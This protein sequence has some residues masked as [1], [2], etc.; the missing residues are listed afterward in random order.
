[1]ISC[2]SFRFFVRE[3]SSEIVLPSRVDG[4]RLLFAEEGACVVRMEEEDPVPL[5]G[6]VCALIPAG[7]VCTVAPTGTCRLLIAEG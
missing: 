5:A 3:F 1:M 6:D 2:P 7:G 4:F